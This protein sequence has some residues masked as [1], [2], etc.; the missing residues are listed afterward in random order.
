MNL[1]CLSLI[2][3]FLFAAGVSA[4]KVQIFDGKTEIEKP[5]ELRDPFV[6]P[7]IKR[8]KNT[9]LASQKSSTVFDD[10]PSIENAKISD[11][12]ITGV[13]IG[14]NRRAFAKI[15][16][17]E[18]IIAL[19]EGMIIGE[20]DAELKAILAGGIILVE[21]TVNIYGEEEYLETVLPIS[22]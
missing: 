18:R 5:F 2:I 13:I 19:K 22:N 10:T 16:G 15:K 4:N 21:K 9:G 1:K 14:K 20:N 12:S 3:F 11:I 6:A 8:S 7:R 17:I